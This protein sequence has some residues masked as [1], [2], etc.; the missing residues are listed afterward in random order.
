M[1]YAA[2]PVSLF[3]MVEEDVVDVLRG[4]GDVVRVNKGCKRR[5]HEATATGNVSAMRS[6]KTCGCQAASK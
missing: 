6:D 3:R 4:D 1:E 5:G 2:W